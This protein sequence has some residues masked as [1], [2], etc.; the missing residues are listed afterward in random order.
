MYRM[1]GCEGY[2][3]KKSVV[4]Y[5]DKKDKSNN[6]HT[7]VPKISKYHTRYFFIDQGKLY[8]AKTHD[9][10]DMGGKIKV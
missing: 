9:E 6:T 1:V 10:K 5:W 8:Y 2:L 7:L 3:R 4:M